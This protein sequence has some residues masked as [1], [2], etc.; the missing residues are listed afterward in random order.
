MT[1]GELPIE[2]IPSYQFRPLQVEDV[3]AVYAID[4]ALEPFPWT[5]DIFYGCLRVGY[6]AVVMV[7][8]TNTVIIGFALISFVGA[9]CDILNIAIRRE[10]Q[11]RGLGKKLLEHVLQM[12][13]AGGAHSALLEVRESNAVAIHLYERYGFK[14]TA[15]RKN[16]YEDPTGSEN[17]LIYTLDLT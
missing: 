11:R 8:P 3:P 15:C 7:D 9:Q 12:A 1:D 16:Y 10:Q 2:P 13:V 17:A 5:E 4:K 14:Q 6:P